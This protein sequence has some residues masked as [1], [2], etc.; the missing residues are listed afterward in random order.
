MIE[1]KTVVDLIEV[2]RDGVV[3]VRTK[4]ISI[5]NGNE[6]SSTFHRHL[7]APGECGNDEDERVKAVCA[8]AHTN[9][10]IE[11]YKSTTAQGV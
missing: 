2:T 7:I 4:T 3:Q 5:E 6:I 1:K 9:D 11:A 10:V 8:E